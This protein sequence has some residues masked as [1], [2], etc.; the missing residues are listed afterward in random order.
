MY[1]LVL[2]RHGQSLWNQ[3]NRFT[4]WVDIDLTQQG[5]IEAALSGRSLKKEGF[6]F[7]IA[8]TSYLKRAIRTLFVILDEMDQMWIPVQKS[9]RLNE[10]H[11]GALTGL[12]KD[13]MAQQYGDEQVRLWRRSYDVC[14]ESIDMDDPRYP[15]KDR[16]YAT[17][18]QDMIPKSECLK[19][20]V[21]RV[22]P[23]WEDEIAPAIL[24][25]KQAIVV[26]HGNTL[27]SLIKHIVGMSDEEII[28]FNVPTGI[29]LIVKLDK[30]L[31]VTSYDYLGDPEAIKNAIDTVKNQGKS[32]K[33]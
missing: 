10:R 18:P 15:G 3:E 1:T 27:R 26:S 33:V 17:L 22:I 21:A 29:P 2:V 16:R 14:P 12:R 9:W 25:G 30:N 19:D 7:D 4:G 28:E 31:K 20:N 6:E 11:Y 23:Y 5:I 24:A 8:F 13:E 32:G